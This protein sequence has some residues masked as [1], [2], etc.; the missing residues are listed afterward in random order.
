MGEVFIYVPYLCYGPS[1]IRGPSR[2]DAS[3]GGGSGSDSG[4]GICTRNVLGI[5]RWL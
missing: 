2:K 3:R 5:A 1:L 4:F